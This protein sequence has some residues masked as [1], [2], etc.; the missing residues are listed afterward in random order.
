MRSVLLTH[1]LHGFLTSDGRKESSTRDRLNFFQ[2]F[3]EYVA[4]IACKCDTISVFCSLQVFK[5]RLT[6]AIA[7]FGRDHTNHVDC[8]R[9]PLMQTIV[10]VHARVENGQERRAAMIESI[11]PTKKDVNH[12]RRTETRRNIGNTHILNSSR[13]SASEMIF[14]VTTADTRT[15]LGTSSI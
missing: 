7:D 2:T 10:C 5:A 9:R 3:H 11:V 15:P 1:C 12:K 13:A 4:G 8:K 6:T 14:F